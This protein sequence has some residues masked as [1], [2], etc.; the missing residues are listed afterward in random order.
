MISMK[1]LALIIPVMA[2]ASASH[3]GAVGIPCS[4]SAWNACRTGS[5]VSS[6]TSFPLSGMSSYTVWEARNSR[7]CCFVKVMSSPTTSGT[8]PG[9]GP[10]AA[11]AAPPPA[12]SVSLAAA[13]AAASSGPGAA[14]PVNIGWT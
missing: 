7:T 5:F 4:Y 9:S 11:A 14:P 3:T 2:Q 10:A 6:T 8:P 1:S 13:A 12:I